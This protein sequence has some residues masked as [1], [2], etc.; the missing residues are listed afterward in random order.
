MK[1]WALIL[2]ASSGV[3]LSTAK[4][5]A[6]KGLNLV[7]VHRDRRQKATEFMSVCQELR[8]YNV[9]VHAINANAVTDEGARE[10][11][12]FIRSVFMAE[13]KIV[14]MLHSIAD[15]NIGSLFNREKKLLDRYSILRTID[16]MGVSFVS[17][18]QWLSLENLFARGALAVGMS[19][20]GSRVVLTGYAAVGMAKA[21]LEA[22]ARYM[23]VELA[24]LG[25][26]VNILLAGVMDTPALNAIPEA[27]Q[28]KEQMVKKN[29]S[30]RLTTPDDV[31]K[32]IFSLLD[33][34]CNWVNGTVIPVD[35]GE[36]LVFNL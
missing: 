18:V 20:I 3:G 34:S 17:W 13:D 31:A 8:Q 27:G 28:L 32:V 7:L 14:L 19:S 23:A 6:G 24:P 15:G 16:A 12:T 25:V 22:S 4:L 1:K 10:I 26:R 2:G 35:G 5:L 30:G 9:Q 21:A 11:E 29:P 33:P 36:S